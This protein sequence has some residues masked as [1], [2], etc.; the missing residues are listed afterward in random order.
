MGYEFNCERFVMDVYFETKK[1][2]RELRKQLAEA[3]E[4]Y[5][6]IL[7]D[8]R[9][10]RS[11]RI[12]INITKSLEVMGECV[13]EDGTQRSRWFTINLRNKKTD[14]CIFKTL[15]HEM[16]HVKQYAKNELGKEFT[17]TKGGGF[18]LLTNWM[19]EPWKPKSKEDGYFDSPWEIEAYGREVGLYKRWVDHCG[20]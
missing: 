4:F 14:D 11:L 1:V 3:C 2:P 9:M 5:A 10:V 7:M 8:P 16:V 18:K 12:D 13:N 15:A 20:E 19:G 6:N 17:V